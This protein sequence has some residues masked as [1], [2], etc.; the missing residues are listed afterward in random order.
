MNEE[1]HEL[2]NDFCK[3]YYAYDDNNP[4]CFAIVYNQDFVAPI[5]IINFLHK[6]HIHGLN[7]ILDWS[8]TH[9][10]TTSM[11]QLVV[12]VESYDYMSNLHTYVQQ[13]GTI[14]LNFA[15]NIIKSLNQVIDFLAQNDSRSTS[16]FDN[17]WDLE[18][19]N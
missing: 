18:G 15:E 6:N 7:P 12:I 17:L 5:K 14:N 2:S 9:I 8:I 19:S 4:K 3:Y 16:H 11:E 10:S 1:I 13:Q